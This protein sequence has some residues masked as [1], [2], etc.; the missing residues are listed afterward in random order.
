M[1]PGSLGL[2][3]QLPWLGL[4]DHRHHLCCSGSASSMCSSPP[5]FAKVLN[6]F[7]H[8]QLFVTPWTI[9]HQAPLSMGFPSEEYWSRLP[10]PPPGDLP[11]PV[12]KPM[13]LTSPAL[14]GGFFTMSSLGSL[15]A[16]MATAKLRYESKE[17]HSSAQVKEQV[18]AEAEPQQLWTES[19]RMDLSP[20]LKSTGMEV[21]RA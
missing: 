11:N 7:S 6:H 5:S 16:K 14:A 17:R 1:L 15:R 12:I 9:A 2:Q 3:A 8:V 20:S 19:T 4:Q 10:W 18:T 21:V 13:S